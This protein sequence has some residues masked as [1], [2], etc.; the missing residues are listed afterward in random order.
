MKK[1]RAASL[2]EL[3]QVKGVGEKLARTIKDSLEGASSGA[4]NMT[5]GEILD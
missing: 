2:D 4:V 5:T 3:M 1:I